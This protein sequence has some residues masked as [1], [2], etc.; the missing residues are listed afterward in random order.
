MS[1]DKKV[2]DQ[3]NRVERIEKV[4]K[5]DLIKTNRYLEPE[6]SGYLIPEN[7]NEKTL[8]ISQDFL[9]P[10]LP[11]YN[12]DNIFNLDLPYGPYNVDFSVNG[13]SL[14]MGGEKGHLSII[15][16]REKNLVCELNVNERIN[17]VKFLHND[18]M[19]AVAQQKKVF[20]YDKQGIELHALEYLQKPKFL[21]FLPHHFLLVTAL[22]NNYIKYL[23]VSLGKLVTEIKTKSGDITCMVQNPHNAVIITG[24]SNGCVNMWTPNFAS[25]PVVKILTHPGA[26]QSVSVDPTGQ[27]LV[28]T[29]NDCKMKVWDLRHN[30]SELYSYFNPVQATSTTIS[31]KGLLA[32]SH[33]SLVEVWKDYAKS[34]QK[35]PYMKHHY[36]N[37]QTKTNSMKFVPFED[38][39]GLGT[40]QGYS[41]VVIP[42]AG[43]A[44]FDS[45]EINPYQ[46]K[47]Q[48]QTSEVRQLLEKLPADMINV[49]PTNVNKTD[50][51]SRAII[52]KE[53]KEEIKKK[54][55]DMVKN[56]KKKLKMR[57]SNKETHDL[58]LKEF[59]KNQNIRNKM[60][61]V[62]EIKSEKKNKEKEVIKSDVKVLK[63]LADDFDPELYIKEKEE[64][65][66]SDEG[67]EAKDGEYSD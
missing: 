57:L 10:N 14:L 1:F 55:D 37:N 52:D 48:R 25:E 12:K 31:Q 42:G 59:N 60:R 50:P 34:K 16:W 65:A 32:V 4:L 11:K 17:A 67:Q 35:E 51:R 58:I 8:K 43:E 40:N 36:K 44:N 20:I 2:H 23:D 46:T 3:I 39:L 30:Y 22:R 9:M 62:M 27:Y 47:K 38:F 45:F 28:T 21:E 54:A 53:K 66:D 24:H 18:T 33:G 64:E 29:G 5:K 15:E 7:E 6:G 41:S 56:Q 19:F 26:V 63:M 61:A 49:D 13:S